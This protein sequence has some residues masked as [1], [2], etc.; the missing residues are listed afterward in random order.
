M[1]FFR[2]SSLFV[3]GILLLVSLIGL[4][5]LFIASS[6]LEYDNVKEGLTNLIS[7]EGAVED[8]AKSF[9]FEGDI[10]SEINLDEVKEE[11]FDLAKE[12]CANNTEY[13]FSEGGYT[14]EIPCEIVEEGKDSFINKTVE[15]IVY[16]IYYDDYDCNFWDC[17]SEEGEMGLFLISEKSKDYWKGKLYWAFLISLI[18]A[19]LIFLIVE[20]KQNFPIVL[21]LIVLISALPFMKADSFISFLVEDLSGIVIPF[22]GNIRNVFWFSLIVGFLFIASG[23]AWR[24]LRPDL[25]KKKFSKKDIRKIVKSESGKK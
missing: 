12:Y 21:G 25:L 17:L 13:V 16:E 22:L 1:G 19:A 14:V 10:S 23:I 5:S 7:D 9:G 20:Q 18:L 4:N 3:L 11:I 2:G 24:F 6:S 15:N 8:I